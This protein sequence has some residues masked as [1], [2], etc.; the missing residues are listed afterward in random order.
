MTRAGSP[1]ESGGCDCTLVV[2]DGVVVHEMPELSFG[3]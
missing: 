3:T 1:T 2:K